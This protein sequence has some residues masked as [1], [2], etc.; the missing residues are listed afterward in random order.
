M[1]RYWGIHIG[2]HIEYEHRHMLGKELDFSVPV[3]GR[4]RAGDFVYLFRQD[5][6]LY[7]YGMVKSME[8]PVPAPDGQVYRK[9]L[10]HVMDI[11]GPKFD[12]NTEIRQSQAFQNYDRIKVGSLSSFDDKQV[13]HLNG[14]CRRSNYSSPPDPPDQQAED[15]P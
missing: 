1:P 9:V 3:D 11:G 6:Y 2:I 12:V 5:E 15:D 13:R 8:K 10:V 4:M 7:G 14:L